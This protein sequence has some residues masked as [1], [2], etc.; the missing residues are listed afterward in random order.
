MAYKIVGRYTKNTPRWGGC[1]NVGTQ[2]KKR[3][4]IS[5]NDFERYAPDTAERWLNFCGYDVEV[6]Q[7]I[8]GIWV[9]NDKLLEI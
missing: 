4:Y 9:R 6:Y 5:R 3:V 7:T 2:A 8:D 1:G